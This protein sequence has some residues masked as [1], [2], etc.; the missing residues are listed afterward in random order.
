MF[1]QKCGKELRDGAKFCSKCGIAV[2][3]KTISEQETKSRRIDKRAKSGVY[4]KT[5]TIILALLIILLGG[6]GFL[7]WWYE[8][9]KPQLVY[10][11]DYGDIKDMMIEDEVLEEHINVNTEEQSGVENNNQTEEEI[12]DAIHK[13]GQF[14]WNWFWEND[15]AHVDKSDIY[16]DYDEMGYE[17]VYERVTYEGIKSIEDVRNLTKHYYT[18]EIAEELINQKQWYEYKDRVYVSVSD[19]L[20]GINPDY[21]D[22]S[23]K[24]DSDVQYTIIVYEYYFDELMSE[25]YEVHYQLVDGYWVFDQ[26][27]CQMRSEEVPINIIGEEIANENM[28]V[29]GVWKNEGYNEVEAWSSSYK[30]V[31]NKDGTVLQEGWRNKDTGT[32]EISEDGRYITAYYFENYISFQGEWQLAED[33]QYTVTYEID[34]DNECLYAQ[35]SEKFEEAFMSNAEDGMLVR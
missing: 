24:K 21:Y 3:Q 4:K 19:G 33:Y 34:V 23:I 1:C 2:E 16:I 14:A 11:E 27:F 6:A 35:Y 31:F 13:A 20:G 25:P 7:F 22:I 15:S 17:W 26:I 8:V 28:T 5:L 30:T 12:C 29:T 10:G 18:A 32:Y 9:N